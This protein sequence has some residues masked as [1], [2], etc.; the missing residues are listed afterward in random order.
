R[1]CWYGCSASASKVRA[2]RPD[3]CRISGGRHMLYSSTRGKAPSVGFEDVVLTG[4]APDGGLYLP[5]TLPHVD[6]AALRRWSKL[7]YCELAFEVMKPFV[8]GSIP[9]AEFRAMIDASYAG[10][11]HPEVAP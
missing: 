11:A 2:A 1:S 6:A 7:S 10:F 9:D 8:D 5:D 4:L 3:I